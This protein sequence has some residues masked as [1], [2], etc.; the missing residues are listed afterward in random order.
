M[1]VLPQ[2]VAFTA[3]EISPYLY[4]RTDL[5]QYNNSAR[6]I[7]NFY[8]RPQGGLLKRSGSIFVSE[9]KDST[10]NTTLIPFIYSSTDY[11][12]LEV[13]AGY[14]RFYRDGGQILSTAA[15]TNSSMT[16]NITGWTTANTG[17][18]SAAWNAANSGCAR[19]S[20]GASGVGAIKQSV[21]YFGTAQYTLSAT[22]YTNNITYSIGT[23]DGGTDLGTGT[24]T[25]GSNTVNFT[26]TTA[27]TV[28]FKFSNSAN[29]NADI[30]N[31]SVNTPT[32]QIENPYTD[33]EIER[34]RYAQSYDTFYLF[35]NAHPPKILT[36]A[37]HAQWG[38]GNIAFSD[39]PYYNITDSVYGGVGSGITISMSASTGT[40]TATASSAIFVST[41]VG[42]FIRYRSVDSVGWGWGIITAYTSSTSVTV[43]CQKSFT[44]GGVS[45]SQWR[46]GYFSDST[47]YPAVGTIFQQ[48]MWLGATQARKQQIW[49]SVTGDLYNMQPDDSNYKDATIDTSAFTY[50]IA[51]NRGNVITGFAAQQFFFVITTGGASIIESSAGQG[52][53]LTPSTITIRSIIG[54]PAAFAAPL[55]TR[56]SIIYPHS[57]GRKLLEITYQFSSNVYVPVDLALLAEQRTQNQIAQ[58][59]V[60]TCPNYLIW[61]RLQDGSLSACTYN[62]EQNI[63]GWHKHTL[64]GDGIVRAI[65]VT[66]G[67]VE[68]ELWMIVE[69]TI[70]GTQKQYV[71]YFAPSFQMDTAAADGVFLDCAAVYS[72]SPTSTIT[73]LDHLE[74]K[75]VE[76]FGD[77][78]VIVVTAPVASG[79]ITLQTPVSTA[80]IGLPYV[81]TLVTNSP[82]VTL[83]GQGTTHGR[84]GRITNAALQFYRS[85][86]G[87][88]GGDIDHLDVITRYGENTVMG[89]PI[90]L[91]SGSYEFP[92]NTD[93]DTDPT[94]HF[95]H[96]LP[97]PCHLAGM[98]Y[99]VLFNT[100]I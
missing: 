77:G 74:G 64:G 56:T 98:V 85:Y 24:W 41:D 53:A 29:N 16:S 36:R 65:S 22:T 21:A 71:E 42:R 73:G 84:R 97:V 45:S 70:N 14:I 49:A 3:G 87:K 30:K 28:Y 38:I 48:R 76:C 75:T 67:L 100:T 11:Y 47:G 58:L 37:G 8:V 52:G 62:K 63:N 79:S 92:L 59:A 1:L 12:Q 15:T 25:P 32:Y 50:N 26:R 68:D 61:A 78:G 40:V 89:N 90:T 69:R 88:V 13:G 23:T 44:T 27:G 6:E 51:D 83:P 54:E 18:G 7:T 4:S 5:A 95:R 72:G 2:Q 31:I 17:T 60:Q 35:H 57:Y 43:S 93:F 46:L 33:G 81:A 9:V 91:Q 96:D 55:V 34:V 19:L 80:L 94:L 66:P 20:G 82:N 10:L 39:G 86:G 99:K